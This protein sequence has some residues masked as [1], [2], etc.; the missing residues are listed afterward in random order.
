MTVKFKTSDT[1]PKTVVFLNSL[2]KSFQTITYARKNPDRILSKV[3]AE[4]TKVVVS[5][6]TL[7]AEEFLKYQVFLTHFGC[8][9][10]DFIGTVIYDKAN[11]FNYFS[12]PIIGLKDDAAYLSIGADSQLSKAIYLPL[13]FTDKGYTIAKNTVR[14]SFITYEGQ[15]NPTAFITTSTDSHKFFISL[16]I[17]KDMS[18][19]HI[20]TAF[21]TGNLHL[22]LNSFNQGSICKFT[23]MFRPIIEQGLMPSKGIFM[24]LKK[25]EISRGEYKNKP[26]VSSSWRVAYIDDSV[27]TLPMAD[28]KGVIKLLK[29]ASFMYASEAAEMTKDIVANDDLDLAVYFVVVTGE[30]ISGD[31]RFL[32]SHS[33]AMSFEWL[34]LHHQKDFLSQYQTYMATLDNPVSADQAIKNLPQSSST[35]ANFVDDTSDED[36]VT[37][38]ANGE[39]LPF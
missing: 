14:L 31:M 12:Y 18:E 25:G 23:N 20:Q 37:V 32:P 8:A 29:D 3:G 36:I 35:V 28:D 11:K 27:S 22:Y 1:A 26:T 16:K 33:G 7:L 2:T 34:P 10:Q 6:E 15:E 38:D 19:D 17:D 4:K 30:H 5:K 9:D 24:V 13:E 21:D 39:E